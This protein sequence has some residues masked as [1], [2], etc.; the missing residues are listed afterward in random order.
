MGPSRQIRPHSLSLSLLRFLRGRMEE[1]LNGAQAVCRAD[2]VPRQLLP[3][4]RGT[5]SL[6]FGPHRAEASFHHECREMNAVKAM[7]IGMPF[8]AQPNPPPRRIDRAHARGFLAPGI[9]GVGANPAL[10]IK[11]NQSQVPSSP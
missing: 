9:L 8:D 2:L 11:K 5:R 7:E 6:P 10:G 1:W 3:L 4:K